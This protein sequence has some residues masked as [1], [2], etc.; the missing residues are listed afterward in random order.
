VTLKFSDFNPGDHN[1]YN[2]LT[3]YKYLTKMKGKNLRIT[4][5]LWTMNLTQSTILNVMKIPHFRRH[6]EANMCVKVLLSCYHGDYLCLDRCITFDSTL[7]H[8]IIEL[9]MQGPDPREFY[10]GKVAD[11]AL[12]QRIKD[13]YSDVEKGR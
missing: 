13:T 12:A 6:Q 8:R 11:H 2:M 5:Q 10:L 1:N 7:I 3:P 9:R 4:P